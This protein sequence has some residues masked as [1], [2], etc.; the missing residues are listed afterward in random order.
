MSVKGLLLAM[1]EP[2]AGFEEEFHDWYDSEHVPERMTVVGFE[3]GQRFVCVSGWPRYL[4]L[5]DLTTLDVLGSPEYQQ[6]A[7]SKASPWTRRVRTKVMGSYRFTGTQVYP[8]GA[9][10]A[11]QGATTQLMLLRFRQVKAQDE[12]TILKGLKMNFA[13]RESVNQVRLFKAEDTLSYIA[14]IEFSS[15]V[16]TQEMV[17]QSFGPLIRKL[18]LVNTYV[19]YS[20][21]N[22]NNK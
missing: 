13:D 22:F 14:A 11:A 2:P 5:Y 7:G 6:A 4:A 3:T 10:L 9:N 19:A 12:G 21:T 20:R 17:P 18:D 16:E 8:G 1:M 15:P